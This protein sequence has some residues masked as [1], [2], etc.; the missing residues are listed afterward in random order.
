[1]PKVSAP[2]A[3]LEED[4]GCC[5][6]DDNA[7]TGHEGPC[8]FICHHCQGTSKCPACNGSGDDGSGLD[9]TCMECGGGSCPFC[10]DGMEVQE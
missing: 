10:Q 7:G 1:M 8:A 6:L 9:Y 2:I 4:Y 5:A 3:Q